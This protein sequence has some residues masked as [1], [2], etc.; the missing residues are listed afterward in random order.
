MFR[1]TSTVSPGLKG[2]TDRRRLSA[3]CPAH[4]TNTT[5]KLFTRLW[6]LIRPI[7][8][9]VTCVIRCTTIYE[10][11]W[12]IFCGRLLCGVNGCNRVRNEDMLYTPKPYLLVHL[13]TGERTALITYNPNRHA[14][15]VDYL[16]FDEPG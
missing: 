8:C 12:R 5:Q 11:E 16:V 14:V 10:L 4:C 1:R 9:V 13:G 6:A 15:S 2:A 3:Y 7:K